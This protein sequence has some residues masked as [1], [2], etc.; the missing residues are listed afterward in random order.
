VVKLVQFLIFFLIFL[1]FGPPELVI[2]NRALLSPFHAYIEG[3]TQRMVGILAQDSSVS[4]IR[5]SNSLAPTLQLLGKAEK[6]SIARSRP[7]QAGT[8][9][10]Q[11]RR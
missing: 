11:G 1:F 8:L 9:C 7:I 3:Q 4:S 5:H 10:K 6:P 2:A